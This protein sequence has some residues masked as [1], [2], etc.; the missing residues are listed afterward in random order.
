MLNI[1]T[2]AILKPQI[3][4]GILKTEKMHVSG[5]KLAAYFVKGTE[6]VVHTR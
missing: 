1:C 2:R 3:T 5:D 6:A 4:K